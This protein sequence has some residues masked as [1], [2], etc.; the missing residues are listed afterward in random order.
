MYRFCIDKTSFILTYLKFYVFVVYILYRYII[1]AGIKTKI[2]GFIPGSATLKEE[3]GHYYVEF[4]LELIMKSHEKVA[5]RTF[6]R[7]TLLASAAI[8]LAGIPIILKAD[9]EKVSESDPTAIALGYVHDA[10]TVDTKKYPQHATPEGQKQFCH[11]CKLFQ[12]GADGWGGCAIFQGK[13]VNGEGWCSAWIA[14]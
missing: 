14:A 5:R 1:V 4:K 13:L 9:N 11:N 3:R 7:N 10:S 6:L 8:P 2:A 12:A